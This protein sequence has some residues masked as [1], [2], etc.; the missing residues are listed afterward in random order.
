MLR[1]Y[2][3]GMR[4]DLLHFV[5]QHLKIPLRLKTTDGAPLRILYPGELNKGSGPDFSN[6]QLLIGNI[7]WAG[8]VEMHLR[9]SD[10]YSHGHQ[11]D[12]KYSR[13]ILHVVY[14]DDMPVLSGDGQLVPTLE[15]RTYIPPGIIESYRAL[16]SRKEK[17]FINCEKLLP[18]IPEALLSSW[19]D[20][21]YLR[22][23]NSQTQ[24][25]DRLY[26]ENDKH[27]EQ[28]LFQALM[29]V[30][31]S[32]KNGSFFSEAAGRLKF[33]VI[34]K[35]R[36]SA[37]GLEALLF[38]IVGMLGKSPGTESYYF[39]LQRE[40]TFLKRKYR[41]RLLPGRSPE[42]FGQR[43][44]NFPTIRLSQLAMLYHKTPDLFSRVIALNSLP[45]AYTLFGVAAS[46]YWSTHYVFGRTT[47]YIPKTVNRK[48]IDLII[49][50][51]VLPLKLSFARQ[52]GEHIH[53]QLLDLT[54]QIKAES[55]GVIDNFKGLGIK[56]EHAQQSQA[57][58]ELY[59]NYCSRHQCL[60]CAVG[61]QLL[62]QI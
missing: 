50:N 12:P 4:E 9:S 3:T 13:I 21:L 11:D 19:I 10:W 51:A 46:P 42:Y 22:R 16:L 25:F 24:H 7:Q 28:V 30:F 18:A 31:G 58:L 17:S 62:N 49:L 43:P 29:R 55:N 61:R 32:R 44:S 57:L 27:W 53:S 23:L 6:A 35:T 8:N 54:R 14:E 52:R 20:E 34:R 59:A 60:S 40:F 38:G 56:P 26:R 33:S 5:W 1:P 45:E 39:Q 48:F 41:L 15:L 2:Y 47:R 37:L 36:T